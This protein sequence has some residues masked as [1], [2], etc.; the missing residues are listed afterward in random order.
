MGNGGEGEEG[1]D[2]AELRESREELGGGNIIVEELLK[3]SNHT[4]RIQNYSEH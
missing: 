4:P 1:G 3:V 2:R